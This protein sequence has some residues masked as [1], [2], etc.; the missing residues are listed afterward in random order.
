MGTRLN[1]RLDYWLTPISLASRLALSTSNRPLPLS[2]AFSLSISRSPLSH[3]GPASPQPRRHR[4][5]AASLPRSQTERA[6]ACCA[7]AMRRTPSADQSPAR[8]ATSWRPVR[9]ERR[10]SNGE[11]VGEGGAPKV[12]GGAERH[13]EE[14][15]GTEEV[16]WGMRRRNG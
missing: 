15:G 7:Q 6:P 13:F 1:I 2:P 4:A 16:R 8:R 3:L 9:G 14:S 10:R 11:D 5:R 12:G